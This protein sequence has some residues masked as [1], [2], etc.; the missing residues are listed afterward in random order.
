MATGGCADGVSSEKVTFEERPEQ[1]E[2]QRREALGREDSKWKAP[3]GRNKLATL[4][5]LR[6]KTVWEG[7]NEQGT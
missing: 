6:K 4:R 5:K 3:R 1:R 7:Q 2:A